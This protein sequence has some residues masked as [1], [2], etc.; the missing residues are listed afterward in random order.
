MARRPGETRG[1]KKLT[2]EELKRRGTYRPGDHG[3]T[4]EESRDKLD[5]RPKIRGKTACG[6]P[7]KWVRN[8]SDERAIRD[9]CWFDE[10]QAAYV[11]KWFSKYL[12]H[13][14]G[15]FAGKPFKPLQW[16]IDEILYPIFGWID[17][18]KRRRFRE[19]FIE[20][21][22]KQGKSTL[23]SGIGLYMLCGDG[24]PGDRVFSAANNKEQAAIVHSSAIAMV[25][26]SDL[27]SEYLQINNATKS[28]YQSEYRLEYKALSYNPRSQEGID[29]HCVICDELHAWRGRELWDVLNY[30]GAARREPLRF[31]ITTAGDDTESVCYEQH[32]MA[33]AVIAGETVNQRFHA[34]IAAAD[35][36]DNLG[37][38]RTWK[39]ANPS[40]GVTMTTD[41]FR[42]D[43]KR[44][45]VNHRRFAR[46]KRYRLNIWNTGLDSWLDKMAWKRC[47]DI[48]SDDHLKGLGGGVAGLDLARK[49][50]LTALVLAFRDA[51]KVRLRPFFW[52]PKATA[53]Q[54][55]GLVD[56]LGY[57]E[58]GYL[59]LTAGDVA[60]FSQIEAEA[61]E[62]LDDFGVYQILFDPY[63]AEEITQRIEN[64][65]G[66]ERVE[67]K[68]TINNYA[69]PTQ[70][71]ER[72]VDSAEIA[73]DGNELLTW[74]AGNVSVYTDANQNMR[75]IKPK[76]NS[77]KTID[78][79]V[80]AI[81][82]A[83]GL[84]RDETGGGGYVRSD[85]PVEFF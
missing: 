29:A 34:Y 81:M 2:V 47:A 40:M 63:Y 13:S 44:D 24:E 76:L 14:I 28:I 67:F 21:P 9:G 16:Q 46:F 17:K 38:V 69:M 36:D 41:D 85:N 19:S 5:N 10:N 75:P 22:K 56:Y 45:K 71:F 37:L 30:A 79:M 73:H 57:A 66:C 1:R 3:P 35:E 59:R 52:L 78:G 54:M 15:R 23:C 58:K 18:S 70:A 65:T 43:Y 80:A 27:L 61:V 11:V 84:M 72:M 55:S 49:A 50:D 8:A 7:H 53:E 77:H 26:S 6:S 33:K 39:K 83:G 32:E 68:Q 20:V 42:A 82:A 60:D 64:Q 62:I 25:Q 12:R 74:Q 51:D 48:V 31:T 4:P